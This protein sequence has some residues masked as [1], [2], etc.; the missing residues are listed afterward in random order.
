MPQKYAKYICVYII[1]III[2]VP[3]SDNVHINQ[4]RSIGNQC[5]NLSVKFNYPYKLQQFKSHF[6]LKLK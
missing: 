2:Y 3:K 6:S 5:F 4:N 1:Y